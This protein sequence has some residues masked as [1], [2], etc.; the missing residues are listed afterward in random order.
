MNKKRLN[1]SSIDNNI[2]RRKLEKINL[3]PQSISKMKTE[4]HLKLSFQNPQEINQFCKNQRLEPVRINQDNSCVLSQTQVSAWL[5]KKESE[6]LYASFEAFSENNI[7]AFSIFSDM[8]PELANLTAR[9]DKSFTHPLDI[10]AEQKAFDAYISYIQKLSP[11]TCNLVALK[12]T[13]QGDVLFN[14]ML[15][16]IYTNANL[17]RRE[18]ARAQL[19]D[20]LDGATKS[21]LSQLTDETCNKLAISQSGDGLCGLQIIIDALPTDDV[22]WFIRRLTNETCDISAL[23]IDYGCGLSTVDFFIPYHGDALKLF[24]K[25]LSPS[26]LSQALFECSHDQHQ[27][28]FG[29]LINNANIEDV[30]RFINQ[31]ISPGGQRASLLKNLDLTHIRFQDGGDSQDNWHQFTDKLIDAVE[32]MRKRPASDDLYRQIKKLKSCNKIKL[33]QRSI[34]KQTEL[35]GWSF[36]KLLGRSILMTNEAGDTLVFKIQKKKQGE[37]KKSLQQEFKAT[38]Y[39]RDNQARFHLMSD[40]PEPLNVVQL[41][42]VIHWVQE[43]NQHAETLQT[44]LS[45]VGDDDTPLYAYVYRVNSNQRNYFT[46]LHDI[47]LTDKQFHE[48]NRKAVHDLF[49][50]LSKGLVFNQLADLY[51]NLD[52]KR[53]RPDRGRYIVLADLLRRME[54]G[55]GRVTGWK[56]AVEYP[57]VRGTGIADVGDCISLNE[58]IG[59][60]EHMKK[61]HGDT[62]DQLGRKSGNYLIA[63]IMAEY[64]YILFLITSRRALSQIEASSEN[65]ISQEEIF[66]LWKKHATQFVTNCVYAVS[67]VTHKSLDEVTLAMNS[68]I[69]VNKLARQMQFWMTN[70]YVNY[71]K[72]NKI[73]P[74]IYG[75]HVAV[76]VNRHRFRFNT[77]HPDIGFSVNGKTPD[78]GP[79]NGQEPIKEANKLIYWMV[80]MIFHAYHDLTFTL[81]DIN[82]IVSEKNVS[83]SESLRKEAFDYLPGKAYHRLQHVLCE[84]RLKSDQRLS[85]SYRHSLEIESEQHKREAAALTL[86]GFWRKKHPVPDSSNEKNEID[87]S[88]IETLLGKRYSR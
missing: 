27:S 8:S 14:E 23:L 68:I 65:D 50:L 62:L 41:S 64:Q 49:V 53:Y 34:L 54:S 11:E 57:N 76:E 48:A 52:A 43:H 56:E 88:S 33:K 79:V 21:F 3:L 60:T 58:Y 15:H 13:P 46:Y 12:K 40:L 5:G 17:I 75:D 10:M 45:M 74:T 20:Q 9:I 86:Q 24:L 87:V 16:S 31:Q 4:N 29:S 19:L 30:Q 2:K 1:D 18:A 66:A 80:S 85:R 47:A 70:E 72:R 26:V 42:G 81:S 83:R 69:D 82:E 63:N 28:A 22:E 84:E 77:F 6:D 25:K 35:D 71:L 36:S 55:S 59:K 38:K 78:L 39:L 61:F 7:K 32:P 67:L 44:F 73:P 51:H 37:N